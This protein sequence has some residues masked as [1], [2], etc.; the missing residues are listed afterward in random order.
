L[1]VIKGSQIG[2]MLYSSFNT[3]VRAAHVRSVPFVAPT[4]EEIAAANITLSAIEQVAAQRTVNFRAR[5]MGYF[6]EQTF[7]VYSFLR[8]F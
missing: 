6:T 2:Y 1:I 7:K 5:G 3:S 4:P 8:E